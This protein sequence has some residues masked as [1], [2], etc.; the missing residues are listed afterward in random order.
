MMPGKEQVRV[1][2]LGKQPGARFIK[3]RTRSKAAVLLANIR[4]EIQRLY[5]DE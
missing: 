5:L 1:P 4:H 2:C 3:Q